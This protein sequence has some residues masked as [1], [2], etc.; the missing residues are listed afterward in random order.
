MS[1]EEF[2]KELKLERVR[3]KMILLENWIELYLIEIKIADL[4]CQL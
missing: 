4:Q 3:L 1:N 2:I